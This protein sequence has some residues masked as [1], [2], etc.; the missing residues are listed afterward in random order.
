MA[1][2]DGDDLLADPGPAISRL[3][4]FVRAVAALAAVAGAL[5]GFIAGV[6]SVLDARYALKAELERQGYFISRKVL[7]DKRRNA[8]LTQREEGELCGL[9]YV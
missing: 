4:P 7:L 5:A 8:P 9:S 2:D 1:K 3:W 6:W